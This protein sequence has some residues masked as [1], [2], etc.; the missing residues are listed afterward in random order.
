MVTSLLGAERG[1][2]AKKVEDR[3]AKSEEGG[4][5]LV[6]FWRI[7]FAA[8]GNNVPVIIRELKAAGLENL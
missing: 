6:R 2:M 3:Q 4:S 8:S 5:L 7:H 1:G